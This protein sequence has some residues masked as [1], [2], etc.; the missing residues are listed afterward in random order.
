MEPR[1]NPAA[2]PPQH[3]NQ[4]PVPQQPPPDASTYPATPPGLPAAYQHPPETP[5]RSRDSRSRAS[6]PKRSR[7]GA[8]ASSAAGSSIHPHGVGASTTRSPKRPF[9]VISTTMPTT[10]INQGHASARAALPPPAAQHPVNASGDGTPHASSTF[11]P[12]AAGH[13]RSPSASGAHQS[14]D[15]PDAPGCRGPCPPGPR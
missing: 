2:T 15:A 1:Q 6:S 4:P 7:P 9:V 5:R 8:G 11:G 14:A 12:A 10:T 3:Q 13:A